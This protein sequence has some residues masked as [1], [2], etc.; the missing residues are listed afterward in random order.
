MFVVSSTEDQGI[1]YCEDNLKSPQG[2]TSIKDCG[3]VLRIGEDRIFLHKD[4][5]T[6]P[7]L[8]VDIKGEAWYANTTP[9]SAGA[10]PLQSGK[11]FHIQTPSG[12][13]TVHTKLCEGDQCK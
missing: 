2:A 1:A 8:R 6:N 11:T 9:I 5:R 10:Q 3:Y 4:K 7:S 12:E 13:Y